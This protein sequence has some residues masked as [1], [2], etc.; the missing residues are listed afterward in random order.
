[1]GNVRLHSYLLVGPAA[2]LACAMAIG[3]CHSPVH[4][5]E[6]SAVTDSLKNNSLG[7]VSVAQNREN[8]VMTLSGNV[9]SQ[10][11][12]N[13]AESLAKQAAPDYTVADEIGVRPPQVA[14]AG[15]VAS[16]LDSAIEDNF[17]A[18]IKSHTNLDD[19]S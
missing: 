9:D 15:A 8:G 4:P 11:A 13:R 5:D 7:D 17:K 19:Q 10:E 14:N 16:D 3:G 1:M 12:K 2:V 18:S 6:K